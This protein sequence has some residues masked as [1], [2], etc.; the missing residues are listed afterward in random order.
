M[1]I[2]TSVEQS[3]D[4]MTE[5]DWQIA[6]AIAQT[7]VK[8]ETDVNELGKAIAYLRNTIHQD[9]QTAGSRFF[10]YLKTLINNGR[11][12]GHSG[13][14]LDYYRSIDKVCS[15]HLGIYQ[16][17]A[18]MLLQIL[19]WARRLMHYYKEGGAITKAYVLQKNE[20]ESPKPK[21]PI[22]SLPQHQLDQVIEAKVLK[23]SGI[24]VTYEIPST[25][26]KLTEKEPKQASN[27]SEGQSVK[28]RIVA[29]KDNGNIKTVKY[30][31]QS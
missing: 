15:K 7:L 29:L 27:L 19:S 9:Q 3:A 17:N 31:N 8:Q 22:T 28:V 26:Q 18:A 23:I 2:E 30:L 20:E 10:K 16:S 5:A 25:M 11:T 13:R 21:V 24:K 14:T 4:L 1:P 6:H 12:I